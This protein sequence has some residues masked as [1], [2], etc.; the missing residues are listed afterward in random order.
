MDADMATH[1]GDSRKQ[2]P[3]TWGELDEDESNSYS[4]QKRDNR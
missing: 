1:H 3:Q 2:S 4:G